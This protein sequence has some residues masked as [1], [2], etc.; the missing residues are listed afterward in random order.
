MFNVKKL[1]MG[2]AVRDLVPEISFGYAIDFCIGKCWWDRK[3]I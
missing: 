1:D 2:V 3:S